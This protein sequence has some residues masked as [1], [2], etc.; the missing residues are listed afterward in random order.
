MHP[1][2]TLDCTTHGVHS[3]PGGD[4]ERRAYTSGTQGRYIKSEVRVHFR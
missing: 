3:H 2:N 4:T 1:H